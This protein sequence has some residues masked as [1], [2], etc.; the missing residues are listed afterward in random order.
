MDKIKL[1]PGDIVCTTNP[2]WLGRAINFMQRMRAKDNESTYSHA[3]IILDEDGTYFEANWTNKRG[4]FF[5]DYAKKQVLIGRHDKMD[6]A[7]FEQGWD[8]IKDQEGKVYAGHRL[9]FFAIFPPLAKWLSVGIGVC[10]ELCMKFL[11]G[12]GLA[13]SWKGWNPDDVAD[14]IHRYRSWYV[15]FEGRV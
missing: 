3:L 15:V 7:R 9:L 10:S 1:Q 12:A 14:M 6:S 13:S 11:W 8:A 4:N 2:M 5:D